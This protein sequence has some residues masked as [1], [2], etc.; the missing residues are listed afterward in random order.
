MKKNLLILGSTFVLSLILLFSIV[1]VQNNSPLNKELK[2]TAG[3]ED[4][5]YGASRFRYDM[6][7]GRADKIDPLARQRAIK[8]TK[9]NLIENPSVN[10]LRK[11]E[12]IS[13]WSALGPGNI[14]GRIR[15]IIIRPSNS[16]HI[17][18]GS[19]SGG[20]WKS[21][22][23]GASWTP[24]IDDGNPLAIGSMVN[25]GDVVYA[26][27]GEGWFNIDAVYG[28]GIWKSTDFGDT[29]TLLSSTTG[30]NV[31]NFRD[32]RQMRID[33]SGNVYAVTFAYNRK[34]GVGNYQ[35][36]GG[37]Y[38]ST[39]GGSSWS[40]IST[41][42][43]TNYFNGTDAIPISSSTILFATNANGSTL[44]GIFRTTDGGT[45]WTQITSGLPTSEYGRIVM[46]QDPNNSNTVYAV[47]TGNGTNDGLNGIY[48]TTDGGLNWL[49]LPKPGNLISTGSSY[50]SSQGWYDNVISVDP[51]NSNNI[52]VGGVEDMKSTDGGNT[53][54][55]ITIWFSSSSV[56]ADHHAIVFD[57]NTA[58]VV[59]DGND[60]GI[61]KSTNGGSNWTAL[62]NGLEITQFYGGA[63]ETSGVNY[64]GGTQ[65]NGHLK[66]N[67]SGTNW[68]EA[69]G[70]DGG[71]AEI[72]QSNSLVAYEEY[73][74]LDISKTTDGGSTWNAVQ[75]GLTDAKDGN[76]CLF[77][78]PFSMNPENSDVL[79]AGSD[80]AWVTSDAA[81]NWGESSLTLSSGAKVSAVTI[82]NSTSPYLGFAGTT[83]GKVFKSASITGTGDTWTEITPPSNN[84]AW[85][86]RI[87]VDL[88]NKNQIYACYS[89]Y[90]NDG[91]TPTKHVWYSSNQGTSWTDISGNLP[92]VPVHSLIVDPN[93]SQ[94]LYIGT[95]TGVYQ[96]D[97]H[98]TTWVKK[99]SGMPDFVPVDELVR[100]TGTNKLFAFTHGRSV[101][102]TDSP[103]PVE[104]VTFSTSTNSEIAKLNWETAT[105]VNNYGFEIERASSLKN[106]I[107]PRHDEWKKVGFVKGSGNSNSLHK[108]TFADKP[109][110]GTKFQY[111]LKQIDVDGSFTYSK[112]VD[113]NLIINSFELSQNYPNPFNP[114]T[115]INYKL[116]HKNN[117]T[118][119]IYDA[120]GNEVTT[121]VNGV[122][123]A[124]SYN[125]KFDAS[126]LASGL[127]IY[128]IQA[129]NFTQQ[130][131]MMLLK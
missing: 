12:N 82:V 105:E 45:N 15:S 98:G 3:R 112:V 67:G 19:V 41:T 28:G 35:F 65:D 52:Y 18:I 116:S 70:G 72:S 23:G 25:D 64:Q 118:L 59:Y 55:Q 73:V 21:V 100:Q 71:Y 110:E 92:D 121:L 125:V 88:N 2:P 95:E 86:R 114:T 30:S 97:D 104:L 56:H 81:A 83:D 89:G 131:K 51:Y 108:Y 120:L 54:S 91:V 122:K 109:L 107:T 20:I 26:G 63:T 5:P 77:I 60:G 119:K 124:G 4:D 85:V 79:I 84:G 34:G 1:N 32:V 44:G 117:V 53:W 87:T 49:V 33:P 24:K 31:W 47:F 66:Y 78:A 58:D 17:L 43:V 106:G 75:N 11:T 103:L 36:N 93:N 94:V 128:R 102:S 96:T 127:Y 57:P 61:Y 13:S 46:A 69:A 62:N 101:F 7:R 29:W 10:G 16:N 9:E 115:I 40:K 126:N 76:L 22:D 8:Y 123:P 14:G 74:Y 80:N 111:R 99:G 38:K 90:N 50:L 42:S 113:V 130:K 129:G 39:D 27:T 37:L 68:S 48:K 6:I